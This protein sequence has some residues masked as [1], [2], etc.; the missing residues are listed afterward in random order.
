VVCWQKIE[1]NVIRTEL[2]EISDGDF[3]REAKNILFKIKKKFQNKQIW[4]QKWDFRRSKMLIF[5]Y[6]SY[7]FDKISYLKN[8]SRYRKILPGFDISKSALFWKISW[9]GTPGFWWYVK[10][11]SREWGKSGLEIKMERGEKFL[12]DFWFYRFFSCSVILHIA[13]TS[14]W[15]EFYRRTCSH[16]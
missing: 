14:I 8:E 7:K 4:L 6:I 5:H 12:M 11:R 16:I 3:G 1:V 13:F 15:I 2:F 10:F 9:L